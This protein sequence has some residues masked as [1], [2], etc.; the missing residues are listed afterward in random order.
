MKDLRPPR[1]R[2]LE[3]W[4][5]RQSTVTA[6]RRITTSVDRAGDG[7]VADIIHPYELLRSRCL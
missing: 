3:G 2:G 1:G 7:A 6:S 4:H 5:D